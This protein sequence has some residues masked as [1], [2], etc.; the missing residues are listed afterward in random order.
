MLR[1]RAVRPGLS[2]HVTG[3]VIVAV[4]GT[5][6]PGVGTA[7]AADAPPTLTTST[8]V[9]GTMLPTPLAT[10]EWKLKDGVW[11]IH[12]VTAAPPAG[13]TTVTSGWR[14]PLMPARNGTHFAGLVDVWHQS[15]PGTYA[16]DTAM[17]ACWPGGCDKWVRGANVAPSRFAPDSLPFQVELDHSLRGTVRTRGKV[18]FE[19]RY[20]HVQTGGTA[21][22]TVIRLAAGDKAR[23]LR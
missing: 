11:T 20:K 21:G 17:R 23:A 10:G 9:A 22:E 15:A 16:Y 4:L 6:A 3:A 14:S 18:W 13:T 5:G 12:L 2:R 19:W 1:E 7:Q 8:T